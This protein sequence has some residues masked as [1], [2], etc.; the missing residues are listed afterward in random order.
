MRLSGLRLV[1]LY[2]GSRDHLLR[3]TFAA[4]AVGETP[5]SVP[6]QRE[7]LESRWA[8]ST[9]LSESDAGTRRSNDT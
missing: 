5:A 4:T 7:I 1:G 8:D 6:N 2:F 9:C 3:V